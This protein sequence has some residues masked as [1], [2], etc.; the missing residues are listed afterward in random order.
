MDETQ[1]EGFIS[2]FG[3]YYRDDAVEMT[4]K[5][6]AYEELQKMIRPVPELDYEKELAEYREE[7]LVS[8]I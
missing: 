1:L 8:L 4:E 5:Q 3:V 7:K 6:K 2:L